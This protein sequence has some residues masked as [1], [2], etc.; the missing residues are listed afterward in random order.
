MNQRE[1]VIVSGVRTA[2][3]DFG[4]SLKDTPPTQLG[5]LVVKESLARTGVAGQDPAI[6]RVLRR[7]VREVLFDAH[8]PLAA[9]RPHQ[10]QRKRQRVVDLHLLAGRDVELVGDDRVIP[11]R[12]KAAAVSGVDQAH[13]D[14][15][16]D[17]DNRVSPKQGRVTCDP[18]I[19]TRAAD[20]VRVLNQHSNDF[21]EAKGDDRKVIALQSQRRHANNQAG[22]GGGK[23]ARDQH[24]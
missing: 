10:R 14:V 19:A 22:N 15:D 8:R 6:A 11:H 5:A 17:R 9:A 24:A 3:G 23:A 7:A 12:E 2:I 13:D 16:R 18:A 1:V 20:R 21:A 4:G